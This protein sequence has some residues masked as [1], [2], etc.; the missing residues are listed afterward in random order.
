L[1]S[2]GLLTKRLHSFHFE[3]GFR[4]D[5]EVL[6]EA[7]LYVVEMIACCLDVSLASFIRVREKELRVLPQEHEELL[8]RSLE[9]DIRLYLLH[10]GTNACDLGEAV[11]V[12]LVRSHVRRG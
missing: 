6:G 2:T 4:K 7:L 11:F 5:A 12:D 8:Q 9:T 1:C 10:L 3:I